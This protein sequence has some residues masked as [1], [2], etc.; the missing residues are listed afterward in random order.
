MTQSNE[1]AKDAISP[2]KWETLYQAAL[3]SY[4]LA[5]APYSKFKVG[6]AFLMASGEIFAGCNIENASYGATICAERTALGAAVSRGQQEPVA[7]AVVA[8]NNPP[9]SPCG[10]CRQFIAEFAG[11]DLPIMLANPENAREFLTL[12]DL[13]PHSFTKSDLAE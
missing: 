4:G 5:Y 1:S 12:A 13:L 8:R 7:L 11:P 2:D 9:A 3:D 6:A 10:I